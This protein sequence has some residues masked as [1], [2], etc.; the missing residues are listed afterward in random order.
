MP[1]STAVFSISLCLFIIA[2]P[3]N[4]TSTNIKA[5]IGI[6]VGLGVCLIAAIAGFIYL[7]FSRR[8]R[9]E[10]EMQPQLTT[11]EAIDLHHRTAPKSFNIWEYDHDAHKARVQAQKERTEQEQNVKV[12][13][14]SEDG[15]SSIK[16]EG[17]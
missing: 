5:A 10:G 13:Y 1:Q 3:V 12:A 4:A 9:R 15:S 6:G 7:K 17:Y 16:Q 14:G 8:S 2:T 11:A